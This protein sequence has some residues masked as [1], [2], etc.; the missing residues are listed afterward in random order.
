MTL[1]TFPLVAIAVDF[2]EFSDSNLIRT[3][4]RY[5]AG[6]ENLRVGQQV[7]LYDDEQN[8]AIGEV[9]RRSGELIFVRVNWST[10]NSYLVTVLRST[11]TTGPAS[12]VDWA[13]VDLYAATPAQSY[14]LTVYETSATVGQLVPTA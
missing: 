14:T 5:A 11:L 10:W 4:E 1:Q 7:L 13:Q 8:A 6:A 3:L 9:E 12:S 2:N